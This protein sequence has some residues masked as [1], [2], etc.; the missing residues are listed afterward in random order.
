MLI[1]AEEIGCLLPRHFNIDL[2]ATPTLLSSSLLISK[3][4]YGVTSSFF[5]H[6]FILQKSLVILLFLLSFTEKREAEHKSC[7]GLEKLEE[8]QNLHNMV[9]LSSIGFIKDVQTSFPRQ[10]ENLAVVY[11]IV[12]SS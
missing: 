11:R 10:P 2:D 8:N 7:V 6:C 3:V 9:I 4:Q 1:R 5:H 12:F